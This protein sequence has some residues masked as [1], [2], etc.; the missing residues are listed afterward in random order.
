MIL[1]LIKLLL[2]PL[3]IEVMAGIIVAYLF[4]IIQEKQ[5]WPKWIFGGVIVIIILLIGVI[6]YAYSINT[7]R[8]VPKIIDLPREDA[9]VKLAKKS[10]QLDVEKETY[11]KKDVNLVITQ[12]PIAGKLVKKNSV[13]LVEV[14]K[15]LPIVPL[16]IG[17]TFRNAKSDLLVDQDARFEINPQIGFDPNYGD[18][19]IIQQ[20][21]PEGTRVPVGTS[22]DVTINVLYLTFYLS[23][24]A[25]EGPAIL[26][27]ASGHIRVK[28]ISN[29]GFDARLKLEN[30]EANHSYVP[31]INGYPQL[32]PMGN[33]YLIQTSN[34]IYDG[35][36]FCDFA[37]F[38]IDMNRKG[39]A[40]I[41]YSLPEWQ[42]TLKF[43]VKD[44]GRDYKI[45]LYNDGIKL[46]VN[47]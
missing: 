41:S 1:D 7:I 47:R 37:P 46:Q 42:Y 25:K 31:A 16:F 10:L 4:K 38:P 6:T 19:V 13:V 36:G 29:I 34:C 39:E 2:I 20:F 5:Q 21:P 43:F 28:R 22:I 23:P 27:G 24:Y 15:G 32:D 40:T 14:S 17:K 11:I 26:P 44:P 45:V 9:E 3:I 30:M 33:Q 18:S 8:S 12:N 35:E